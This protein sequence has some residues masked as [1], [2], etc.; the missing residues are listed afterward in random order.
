MSRG[1]PV[2]RLF[3]KRGECRRSEKLGQPGKAVGRWRF[4]TE[5]RDGF[6]GMLD[7]TSLEN[8]PSSVG[9]MSIK[10]LL[11]GAVEIGVVA[12]GAVHQ[13]FLDVLR[14]SEQIKNLLRPLHDCPAFPGM[15]QGVLQAEAELQR[16]RRDQCGDFRRIHR[17]N[18]QRIKTVAMIGQM[19]ISNRVEH[20][21]QPAK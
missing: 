21:T 13:D 12:M 5:Y 6:Q 3:G 7:P 1:I 17:D 4:S 16:S 10:P 9:Q 19:A 18:S 8:R 15:K 20:R 14:R 2:P 11:S